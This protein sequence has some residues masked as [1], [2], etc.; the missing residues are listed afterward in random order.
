MPGVPATAPQRLAVEDLAGAGLQP[1]DLRLEVAVP[2]MTPA[3]R[4]EEAGP[5]V[6]CHRD[7][8]RGRPLNRDLVEQTEL[9]PLKDMEL[10][11]LLE[12]GLTQGP[13][14]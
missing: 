7:R 8:R 9:R 10:T 5:R 6:R 2:G 14:A 11:A 3:E 13:P 4:A 1:D 12:K